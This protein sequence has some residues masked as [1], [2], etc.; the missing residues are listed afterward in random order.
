MAISA[1][2]AIGLV[3][4]IAGVLPAWSLAIAPLSYVETGLWG[5][6]PVGADDFTGRTRGHEIGIAVFN[7]A[8]TYFGGTATP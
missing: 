7:K 2:G 5:G 6:I 1:I 3:L 8:V 4:R